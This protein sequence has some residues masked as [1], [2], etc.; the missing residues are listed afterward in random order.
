MV[1]TFD[2]PLQPGP[3]AALN[4]TATHTFLKWFAPGPGTIAG[5]TVSITMQSG[6]VGFGV[7]RCS[8]GAA[9][10][11]VIST[12]GYAADAFANYPLTLIP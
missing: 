7:P 6:L 5:A 1:V 12:R 2:R 4:W 8:Y 10:P 9:P 11:D 3:T